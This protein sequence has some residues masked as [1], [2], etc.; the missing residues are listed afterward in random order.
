MT[1]LKQMN[2]KIENLGS[3]TQR[4]NEKMVKI[5]ERQSQLM[6]KAD[7]LLGLLFDAWHPHL[8]TAEKEWAVEVQNLKNE[9]VQWFLP[10]MNQL[11]S[12]KLVTKEFLQKQSA[13][14]ALKGP[15]L[16]DQ[17]C[18]AFPSDEQLSQQYQLIAEGMKRYE[19][20]YDLVSKMKIES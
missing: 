10:K 7:H 18:H 3:T 19:E 9:L 15:L 2:Q 11:R 8:N 4:L 13:E 14:Q 20:L 17:P 5:Q 6:S 12:Q 1:Q 16:E